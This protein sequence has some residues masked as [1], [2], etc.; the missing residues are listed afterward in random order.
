MVD[1][2]LRREVAELR[3]ELE[4]HR[5]R[6]YLLSDPEIPD[7]AFDEMLQRLRAIEEEHPELDDPA[8]P[9]HRVGAA[10]SG[11]FATVRH[12][13][14]MLSLDNVFDAAGLREWIE[15][16]ERN[17]EGATPSWTCELKIDGVAISVRYERGIFVRAVT[18][19]DGDTGE[20]VTANI[21]EVSGIPVVLDLDDPPAVLEVRGEIHYPVAEFN[22]MNDAREQAGEP[23]FANPRNAASG[24]L[25]Q[26]D[27]RITA[28][29]P[30]ALIC[31]GMGVAD[32]LDVDR[33]QAF[34]QL[35]EA[36][37][38][39]V[40]AET[41]TFDAIDEVLAFIEHWGEHRHDPT[42]EIDGVVV[43]VDDF[44]HRRR[45]G[46]TSSAPRWAIAHKYPP[47]E[48][49]TVLRDIF[50]N[51]GRT[52]KVTPF[53]SFDPVLVAGS[54]LQLATLHN[55]DQARAKDVRPG[56]TI[57]VRKAGDVIP[58][59]VGYMPTKRPS[60]VEEAGPWRMPDTCPFCGQPIERLDGEAASYCSNIDCPNRRLES[61]AHYAARGALD[62]EGMGYETARTLLASGLVTNLADLYRL[63][64]D[65]LLA[66][67]GF[68]EKKVAM[69]LDG[70]EQSKQQPLERLLIG[71]N[72]RHIGGTTAR[73]LARAF[74][75]L[76][77]LRAADVEVSA[78]VTGIGTII[79]EAVAAFFANER[80]AALVD[81]LVAL[82]V[83]TTTDRV[84]VERTLEG[85]TFV[86][87]GGLEGYTRDEAKRAVED[88][89]GKVT[90]S[91]SN[92][93]SAVVVGSDAG[94]KADR[95][96][97]LERPILDEA[98]F[99]RLLETG[100][101]PA[102]VGPVDDAAT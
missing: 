46:S 4:R 68:G 10:P 99:V 74:G 84:E 73:L 38:L 70:I 6:Y 29:R 94:S 51:V 59:V 82:G 45:L 1:A 98:A 72:I 62:I 11:A 81:D 9:T 3:T 64:A 44:G 97:E 2:D 90:S 101:L 48:Q 21:R 7:A 54:T 87:T 30:L 37:G 47:E 96:R 77:S 53:A 67:D 34:L 20:D 85:W 69:L 43:K 24:A 79:A 49:Q 23:R 61:L 56:D 18:R 15:R 102:G 8:S 63:R 100:E 28:T 88:R 55:E 92:K 65:D 60:E 35:L 71:L 25:R 12:E 95:A 5:Y 19:G 83:R 16:V 32:G 75:D 41:R 91:V 13:Q 33:H 50:V 42:Y 76:S 80:N 86:L 39:P 14:R 78:A 22:A 31:H 66:L 17:L 52:G 89:G 93:T 36:A 40:A 26:K 57:I 58:E 27:P